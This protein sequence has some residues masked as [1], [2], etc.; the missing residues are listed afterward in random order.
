MNDFYRVV[1]AAS[2]ILPITVVAAILIF[3]VKEVLETRRRR[4]EV[5]RRRKALRRLLADE[6]ERNHFQIKRMRHC[7]GII[8]RLLAQ[9]GTEIH[10]DTDSHGGFVIRLM[11]GEDTL[12][13]SPL[14][15][16]HK[17]TLSSNLIEVANVDGKIFEQA[18]CV[19]DALKELE[20]VRQSI[21][22]QAN[23]DQKLWIAGF[24]AYANGSIAE[25][26]SSLRDFY[27]EVAGKPLKDWKVF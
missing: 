4:Q 2:D 11:E 22:D 9:P 7:V 13:H 15:I 14:G 16:V 20:H 19:N 27:K 8:E 23:D 25:V 12:Q 18:L 1:A 17:D 26:E 10:V 5:K 21:V 6:I 24:P 3:V